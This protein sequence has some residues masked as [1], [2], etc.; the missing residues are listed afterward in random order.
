MDCAH[1]FWAGPYSFSAIAKLGQQY[2]FAA[3]QNRV[4]NAQENGHSALSVG[5]AANSVEKLTEILAFG[6]GFR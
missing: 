6:G 5:N 3:P 4:W 1:Y 2:A